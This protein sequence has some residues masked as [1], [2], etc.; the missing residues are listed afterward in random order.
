METRHYIVRVDCLNARRLA[1]A[2]YSV[3]GNTRD[4]W[5]IVRGPEGSHSRER[6]QELLGASVGLGQI[7][8]PMPYRKAEKTP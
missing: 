7:A 3:R 6:L 5:A 1:N 8:G 4:G 2:G